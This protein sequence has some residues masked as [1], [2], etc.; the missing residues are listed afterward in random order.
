MTKKV[1]IRKTKKTKISN[2]DP[3]VNFKLPEILKDQILREANLENKTVSTYLRDHLEKFMDGSLYE[4]EVAHLKRTSFINSTEFL[5]LVTWVFSKRKDKECKISNFGL[6]IYIETIKRIGTSLP[7]TLKQEFDK[8][9]IDLIQ[10]SNND[11]TYRL[12]SFCE[13]SITNKNFDYQVLED[14]LLNTV[15]AYKGFSNKK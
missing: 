3:S 6:T 12:F 5:Q 1:P 9:L 7:P 11:S 8:V 2:E 4:K 13:P 15:S 14:Y 10:M